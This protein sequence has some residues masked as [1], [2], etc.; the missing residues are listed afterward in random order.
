MT[1]TIVS[2]LEGEG[3]AA[4]AAK[5]RRPKAA[6]DLL[7]CR[8]AR[9]KSLWFTLKIESVYLNSWCA[10]DG[11]KKAIF[12]YTDDRDGTVRPERPRL[13]SRPSTEANREAPGYHILLAVGAFRF[14]PE[15]Q[16]RRAFALVVA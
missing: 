14:G 11:V 5:E 15:G 9:S 8:D 3:V 4:A 13:Q 6:D 2:R 10:R 7:K 1:V 16:E 12:T